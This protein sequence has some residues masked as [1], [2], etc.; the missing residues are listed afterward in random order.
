MSFPTATVN[1]LSHSSLHESPGCVYVAQ[2]AVN[3]LILLPFFL[4]ASMLLKSQLI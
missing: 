1:I 3:L 4:R 2:L